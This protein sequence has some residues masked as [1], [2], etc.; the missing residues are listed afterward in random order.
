MSFGEFASG[1]SGQGINLSVGICGLVLGILGAYSLLPYQNSAPS[2]NI[3]RSGGTEQ[4]VFDPKEQK[5]DPGTDQMKR[6]PPPVDPRAEW[7]KQGLTVANKQ[8]L[9]V[10]IVAHA[11]TD[12]DFARELSV[13]LGNDFHLVDESDA[14]LMIDVSQYSLAS[15]ELLQ[16][17]LDREYVDETQHP[18][19][20]SVTIGASWF[21]GK[22]LLLDAALNK[23]VDGCKRDSTR[24]EAKGDL[25]QIA[26]NYL[27]QKAN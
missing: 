7:K 14:A 9:P 2:K 26:K 23:N 20:A 13:M 4:Q 12:R 5:P 8:R 24:T 27:N 15:K 11:S 21:D 19:T 10:A 6:S 22:P 3:V 16:A 18:S 1:P 17:C 25:L